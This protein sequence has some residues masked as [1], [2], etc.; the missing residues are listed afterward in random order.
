MKNTPLFNNDEAIINYNVDENGLYLND[1]IGEKGYSSPYFGITKTQEGEYTARVHLL[2]DDFLKF[3]INPIIL[4]CVQK[5]LNLKRLQDNW[6]IDITSFKDP[7]DAAYCSQFIK[8]S[9]D[10][11]SI[12]IDILKAQY[13]DNDMKLFNELVD[14][15]IKDWEYDI[16]EREYDPKDNKWKIKTQLI[17]EAKA[18]LEKMKRANEKKK[19]ISDNIKNLIERMSKYSIDNKLGIDVVD[20]ES[21]MKVFKIKDI[22]EKEKEEL[23]RKGIDLQILKQEKNRKLESEKISS[24]LKVDRYA[25]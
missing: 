24:N 22:K 19:S 23:R 3:E 21:A 8:F 11:F 5:G 2:K 4:K 7:R 15:F 17:D 12:L 14:S 18:R 25:R 10:G 20:A 16:V 1:E 9:E 6:P 13:I